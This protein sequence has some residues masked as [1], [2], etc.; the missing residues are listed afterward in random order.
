MSFQLGSKSLTNLVG[1]HPDLVRVVK[2]AIFLT[3][4]DFTV[5]EGVRTVERERELIRTGKSSLKDPYKCRHV[6]TN[7]FS[8]AVD[9]VPLV[10]GKPSWAN[11]II[12]THYLPMGKAMLDAASELGVTVEWGGDWK[13]FKDYPHFQLPYKWYP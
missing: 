1:V 7:G 2:R 5:Y 10:D 8:H 9:L 13:T 3:P 12:K 4:V 11:E 6:P